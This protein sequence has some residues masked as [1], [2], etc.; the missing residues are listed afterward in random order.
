[1]RTLRYR[2]HTKK[3]FKLY[4]LSHSLSLSKPLPVPQQLTFH[5]SRLSTTGLPIHCQLCS[6]RNS[7][8]KHQGLMDLQSSDS[9]RGAS[10][11]DWSLELP[12][13]GVK[14]RVRPDISFWIISCLKYRYSSLRCCRPRYKRATM[15]AWSAYWAIRHR[16]IFGRLITLPEWRAY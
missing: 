5:I 3:G 8:Y 9:S 10:S 11:F 12:W 6:R 2:R 13:L 14:I 4:V 15:N 1:M 16:S 7:A